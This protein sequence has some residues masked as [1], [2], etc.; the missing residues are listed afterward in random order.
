MI[1]SHVSMLRLLGIA[2]EFNCSVEIRN[3]AHLGD[4]VSFQRKD[5]ETK[6]FDF[7]D[8]TP[9]DAM[10]ATLSRMIGVSSPEN[11]A[12]HPKSI[13]EIRA[14]KTD[15]GK[16]WTPRDVLIDTLRQIDEGTIDVRYIVLTRI[17]NTA[18]DEH[19]T[20]VLTNAPDV[21]VTAGIIGKALTIVTRGDD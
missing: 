9:E 10:R 11:F 14:G 6:F 7:T 15:K 19:E 4:V 2:N 8:D 3:D 13:G 1:N 21:F 5:D 17:D 16:D 20:H 12:N 18:P